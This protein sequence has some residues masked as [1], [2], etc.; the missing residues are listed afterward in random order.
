MLELYVSPQAENDLSDIF[1][2][3]FHEWGILQADQYQ[4]QLFAGMQVIL[5]HSNI[6][7]S[8]PYHEL[9]YRVFHINRHLIIYRI[10]EPKCIIVRVL[11]DKMNVD[12]HL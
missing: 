3:T 8:Y 12:L 1:E 2:Y 5:D 7:K 9:P 11:H 4:D 10:E 6:E